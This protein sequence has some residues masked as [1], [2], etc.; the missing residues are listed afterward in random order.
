MLEVVAA[1]EATARWLVRVAMVSRAEELT[2]VAT[3][4]RRAVWLEAATAKPRRC[5][6]HS[7]H[8]RCRSHKWIG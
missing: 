3:V 6:R 2:V 4:A 7:Q 1:S 8:S 5:V